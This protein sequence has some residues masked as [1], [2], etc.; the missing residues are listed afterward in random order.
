MVERLNGTICTA[1]AKFV[2][3][4]VREWDNHLSGVLMEYRAVTHHTTKFS[5]SYLTYGKEFRL[6]LDLEWKTDQEPSVHTDLERIYQILTKLEPAQQNAL[7]QIQVAQQ[8]QKDQYDS[9]IREQ[10]F[11]IGDKVLL[12]RSNLL[13]RHDVKF[14]SKWNGPYYIHDTFKNGS[15]KLRTIDG[16]LIRAPAHGNRLKLYKERDFG[17]RILIEETPLQETRNKQQGNNDST[18]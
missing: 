15:Y 2:Q 7:Q 12:Q 14:E 3:H 6:P 5:P 9:K 18:I 8:K 11:Q 10:T 13:T 4:D 17:P 1:I 16:N